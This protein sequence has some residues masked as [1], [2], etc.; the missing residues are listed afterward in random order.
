MPQRI[1][2]FIPMYNC[3]KQIPRVLALIGPDIRPLFT[4]VLVVDNGS[5]D[6]SVSAAIDAAKNLTGLSVT[7][8]VN[9]ENYSLGGSH[10]VA[11]NYALEN[12]FDYVVV[13]HGDDQ[14]DINDLV[15]ALRRGEHAGWDSMLGS[16]FMKGA[17]LKGYSAFRT[18]GNRVYN[19]VFT[20]A[21]GRRVH[22]LGSGLNIYKTEYL[23]TRFY[24]KYPN[25]LT[26]NNFML[27]AGI[28]NRSKFTFFPLT[29]REEDQR[30]NVKMVR[31]ALKTLWIPLRYFLGPRSLVE[32]DHTGTPGKAY[33]CR[34]VARVE[35]GRVTGAG[36]A[37]QSAPIVAPSVRNGP[38]SV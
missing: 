2:I 5:K 11:F 17:V 19:W 33:T 31:Q 13:L 24:L 4:E 21:S 28:Y 36:N 20:I 38:V 23:K 16:R 26:F 9:T 25:Q 3:Q 35:N 22:D 37:A 18:F 7:V 32:S 27:L 30:S 34:V 6:G 8:V 1:L 10:K 15:P 14:A 29:W 12:G